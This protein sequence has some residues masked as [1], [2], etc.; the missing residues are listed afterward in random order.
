M[1]RLDLDMKALFAESKASEL[2]QEQKEKIE[3][4]IRKREE[5][6]APIYHQV[7]HLI[8]VVGKLFLIK[9]KSRYY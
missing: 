5:I 6:L 2:T 9:L 8:W 4:N 7:K 1:E 3:T